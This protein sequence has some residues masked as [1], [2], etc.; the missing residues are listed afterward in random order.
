MNKIHVKLYNYVSIHSDSIVAY[1]DYRD[2]SR[3][4]VGII[5]IQVLI[6][7]VYY[8]SLCVNIYL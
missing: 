2:W 3:V 8:K 1:C 7:L 5:Q 6:Q 4:E